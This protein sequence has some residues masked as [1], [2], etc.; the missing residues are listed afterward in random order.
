ME[1]EFKFCKADI[2]AQLQ[3]RK[4]RKNERFREYVYNLQEIGLLVVGEEHKMMLYGSKTITELK[5][6]YSMCY[7]KNLLQKLIVSA[8][9]TTAT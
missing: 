3:N 9:T 6:Q 8:V 4:M 2:Y 5:E 1:F 7:M